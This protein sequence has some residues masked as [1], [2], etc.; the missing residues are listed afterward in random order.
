MSTKIFST[1]IPTQNCSN[2]TENIEGEG[3]FE[4]G[5]RAIK[6]TGKDILYGI[7]SVLNN[8]DLSPIEEA[9][10]VNSTDC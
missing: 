8:A 7:E 4:L 1:A 6:A 9:S 2:Q 10:N 5:A 3:G